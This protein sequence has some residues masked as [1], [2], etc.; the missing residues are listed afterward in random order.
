MS[1]DIPAMTSQIL[2]SASESVPT[3]LDA[4]NDAHIP[5]TASFGLE[6]DHSSMYPVLGLSRPPL[7]SCPNVTLPA[8]LLFSED[9]YGAVGNYQGQGTISP[10]AD[11]SFSPDLYGAGGPSFV[12]IY[13]GQGIISSRENASF[14]TNVCSAGDLSFMPHYQGQGTI[15]SSPDT[16]FSASVLGLCGPSFMPY[17]RGQGTIFSSADLTPPT[18]PAGGVFFQDAD[19]LPN[20]TTTDSLPSE[21]SGHHE[22]LVPLAFQWTLPMQPLA[23]ATQQQD[24]YQVPQGGVAEMEPPRGPGSVYSQDYQANVALHVAPSAPEVR[25]Q[26]ENKSGFQLPVET[27]MSENHCKAQIGANRVGPIVWYTFRHLIL[28]PQGSS[29]QYYCEPCDKWFPVHKR[30]KHEKKHEGVWACRI[31]EVLGKKCRP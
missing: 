30:K 29:E 5:L 11:P 28:Y 17:Y 24:R 16:L 19:M 25:D 23:T 27:R 6:S 26:W 20:N 7:T 4:S 31:C 9:W 22:H 15:P 14:S 10:P 18:F 21:D 3:R 1:P 8:P 13:Q 12:P 2:P